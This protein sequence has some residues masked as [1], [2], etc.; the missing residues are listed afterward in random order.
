MRSVLYSRIMLAL[1][2]KPLGGLSPSAIAFSHSAVIS[3]P[4]ISKSVALNSLLM[5]PA[6]VKVPMPSSHGRIMYAALSSPLTTVLPFLS[7][8]SAFGVKVCARGRRGRGT[9]VRP[10]PP[11]RAP[12]AR[13]TREA[14]SSCA[15]MAAASAGGAHHAARRLRL[16]LDGGLANLLE[17]LGEKIVGELANV[18]VHCACLAHGACLNA[19]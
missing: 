3:R 11:R 9:R 19:A 18:L 8:L 1:A 15:W 6:V 7:S 10:S 16:N 4:F 13:H 17:V 5:P 14:E 2:K 12:L